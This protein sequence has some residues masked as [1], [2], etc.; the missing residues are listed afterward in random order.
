MCNLNKEKYVFIY[1]HMYFIYYNYLQ[2]YVNI[3]PHIKMKF[4]FSKKMVKIII[5]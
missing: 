4:Y 2:N 3:K 1:I 5:S